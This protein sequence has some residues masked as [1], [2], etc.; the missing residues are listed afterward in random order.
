MFSIV[1]N[2]PQGFVMLRCQCGQCKFTE[3]DLYDF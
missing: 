1:S 3:H 2:D